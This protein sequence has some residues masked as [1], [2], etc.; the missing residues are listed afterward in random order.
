MAIALSESRAGIVTVTIISGI[1]GVKT[2][3]PEWLKSLG[4]KTKIVGSATLVITILVGL[5]FLKKDS[6]DG[7]LLIWQCSG[8]MIADKPLFGHGTGG[9][10]KEYMLYQASYFRNHPESGYKMRADIVKHPFN[11]FILLFADHF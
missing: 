6:G 3:N 8:Q 5:Y 10:Q 7:R 9:F 1:W 2:L 11:E 4:N